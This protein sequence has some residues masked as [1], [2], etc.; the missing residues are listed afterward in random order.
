MRWLLCAPALLLPVAAAAQVPPKPAE[1][2]FDPAAAS[3]EWLAAGAINRPTEALRTQ[4]ALVAVPAP[5]N[6]AAL[7]ITSR[8][9]GD[10]SPLALADPAVVVAIDA[11]PL[12]GRAASNLLLPDATGLRF[13]SMP[14]TAQG[15]SSLAGTLHINL[16]RPGERLAGFGEFVAGAFGRRLVRGAIDIPFSTGVGVRLE[17]ALDHDNGWLPNPA[18]GERLNDARSAALRGAISLAITPKLSW[19]LGA[20]WWR[21]EAD[22]LPG[23]AAANS[24][25]SQQRTPLAPA[26]AGLL[27]PPRAGLPLGQRSDDQLYSSQL[28]WRSGALRL[29]W[30]A[31]WFSGQQRLVADYGGPL[32]VGTGRTTQSTQEL[33]ATAQLAG[34]WLALVA[35]VLRR[36]ERGSTDLASLSGSATLAADR[37]LDD[38]VLAIDAYAELAATLGALDLAAGLRHTDEDRTLG[39]V[40]ADARAWSPS[41]KAQWVLGDAS[42][43]ATAAR[44]FSG[45]GWVL[46]PPGSADAPAIRPATT[47]WTLRGGVRTALAN[48]RLLLEMAAFRVRGEGAAG[49]LLAPLTSHGVELAAEWRPTTRLHLDGRLAWQRARL[50][51]I[52]PAIAA[53]DWTGSVSARWDWPLPAA[54]ITLSPLA[55]AQY[56][57][58][59]ALGDG[60]QSAPAVLDTQAALQARTLDGHWLASI[61]CSNCLNTTIIQSAAPG[62]PGALVRAAPRRWQFRLRRDF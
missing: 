40:A 47:A 14:G 11:V 34:D 26:F 15:R 1:S 57:S 22:A 27:A 58:R 25:F 54:G 37:R 19:D 35:G 13:D 4:P 29:A 12:P 43:F 59:M 41:L 48:D 61:E 50:E 60:S 30:I 8:G 49:A 7:R 33:R 46:A 44:G 9:L 17:G 32:L 23:I 62:L 39:N 3:A 52:G 16:A 51:G 21:Q 31:G 20:M 18:T 42:L 2:P 45:A 53:P 10:Q 38:R 56:R 24:P 6:G 5:G 55:S 28:E 36:D